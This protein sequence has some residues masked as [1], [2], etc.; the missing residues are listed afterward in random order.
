VFNPSKGYIVTAN[1]KIP[2]PTYPYLLLND[3]DWGDGY[4]ATRILQMITETQSHTSETMRDIQYNT[5]TGL[6]QDF[7]PFLANITESLL[8]SNAKTWKSNMV[9]WNGN[10]TTNSQEGTI[11]EYWIY[12]LGRLGNDTGSYSWAI[13]YYLLNSLSNQSACHGGCE[14]FLASSFSQAVIEADNRKYGDVHHLLI[15]HPV[16]SVTPVACL[17]DRNVEKGGDSYSI[18]VGAFSA[19]YRDDVSN[20]FDYTLG[21]SYRQIVDLSDMDNSQFILPTGNS[22]NVLNSNYDNMLPLYEAGEYV[23]MKMNDY[24]VAHTQK[25]KN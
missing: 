4:R 11:F 22:G 20:P 12:L 25:L 10:L 9:A 24:N 15:N 14:Q 23:P 16:M 18:N 2:P 5:V 6:W 21:P 8:D 17:Y 19:I 1:N 3:H 7:F 13:P